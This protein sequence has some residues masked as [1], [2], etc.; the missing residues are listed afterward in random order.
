MNTKDKPP[1]T[2]PVGPSHLHPLGPVHRPVDPP[3]EALVLGDARALRVEAVVQGLQAV[4]GAERPRLAA[5]G[6]DFGEGGR[7]NA[8]SGEGKPQAPSIG[9]SG[10][11]NGRG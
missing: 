1:R 6:A 10:D 11:V 7:A 8:R 5:D 3:S 9:K 4:L 2:G